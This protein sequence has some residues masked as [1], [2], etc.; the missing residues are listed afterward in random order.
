MTACRPAATAH[1]PS[2]APLR[3]QFTFGVDWE[4][5]VHLL[6]RKGPAHEGLIHLP[7]WPGGLQSLMT[8]RL[9]KPSALLAARRSHLVRTVPEES[10]VVSR[11]ASRYSEHRVPAH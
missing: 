5:H 10:H 6:K 11:T 9:A 4:L 8:P 1:E 7:S 2:A 3:L